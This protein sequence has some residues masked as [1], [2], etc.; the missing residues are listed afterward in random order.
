[1]RGLC[2]SRRVFRAIELGNMMLRLFF[3][4]LFASAV[5]A[6]ETCCV[7]ED[8][9]IAFFT[10]TSYS[11]S[12]PDSFPFDIDTPNLEFIASSKR[13]DGLNTTVGWKS[14]LNPDDARQLLSNALRR[15]NWIAIPQGEDRRRMYQ[16]GF[17]PRQPNAV[18]DNQQFCRNR[19]GQ[20][21]VLSR[22]TDIGTVV[23]L[24]HYDNRGKQDCKEMIAAHTGARRY[25]SG[26]IKYLP[27]LTLPK[28]IETSPFLG[29]GSGG[30]GNEAHASISLQT[31]VS[32][33]NLM[34][35]F[36][37]QMA[38]Q[39]W[40]MDANFQ[41]NTVVGRTWLRDVGGLQLTCIVTATSGSDNNVR[42]R[43]HL[44]SI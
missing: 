12:W 20:L 14:G 4:F 11:R 38:E 17:V 31:T 6:E 33:D 35:G 39:G 3:I 7:D 22:S 1:M 37:R 16:R 43:M 2:F 9:A 23:T 34:T 13:R 25:D 26:V 29:S 18:M 44:E 40:R 5:N 42:L 24:A 27:A 10:Y 21:T 15:D 30:G 32:S 8:I 36:D 28:S 41:G 19:D